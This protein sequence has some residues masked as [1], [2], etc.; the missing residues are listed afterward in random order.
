[1][2]LFN[3]HIVSLCSFG[4]VQSY[5]LY[6]QD[7]SDLPG[8]AGSWS[9][10]LASVNTPK[11]DV[12]AHVYV[13][14]SSWLPLLTTAQ[15]FSFILGMAIVLGTTLCTASI[16]SERS[17]WV[18]G[19]FISLWPP[20]HFLS[21]LFGNDLF[22]IGLGSLGI[23]LLFFGIRIGN[24]KGLC[25]ALLGCSLIPISIW[26]KELSIP[27]FFILVLL[28]WMFHKRNIWMF[29][30][31]TYTSYWSYAW[32]W[33][34]RAAPNIMQNWDILYG[35]QK[36]YELSIH[37][38]NE[39]KIFQL[40]VIAMVG[41]ICTRK[42][43]KHTVLLFVTFIG[44]FSTCALLGIKLR[45][46]Y[47][48]AFGL[49]IWSL[50]GMG[51][52]KIRFRSLFFVTGI[53]MLFLDTWSH[54]FVFSDSRSKWMGTN[55]T[56]IPE[57]LRIWK[58]QYDPIPKRLLRDISL[59]GAQRL[60]SFMKKKEK[61]ATIPLRDERH[62]STL[63]YA[64]IYGGNVLIIE[65]KTCCTKLDPTCAQRLKVELNQAGYTL[66]L[67]KRSKHSPRW[68]STMNAWYEQMRDTLSNEAQ[69]DQFWI[70]EPATSSRGHTPCQKK[71]PHKK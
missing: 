14:G 43:K 2:R 13:W 3:P 63:A 41:W 55:P 71:Q 36:L 68:D 46:R 16:S 15:I 8:A 57:P 51:I 33:P 49:P 58:E 53:I 54:Q 17:T 50:V 12:A 64:Q 23:G 20:L 70:W 30:F 18:A 42:R 67:P 48:I 19:I 56:S 9:L 59:V 40:L 37:R 21:L 45:P 44:V 29:P 60:V 69:Q 1:M 10:Y 6:H 61:I 35:W 52:S 28:P 32:F 38:M 66:L 34:N 27:L 65:P 22:S 4:L 25:F 62:R 24:L 47:L 39:G 11:D 26:A 31:L 7:R 5:F